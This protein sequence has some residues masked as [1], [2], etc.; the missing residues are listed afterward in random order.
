MCAAP[1]IEVDADR[2]RD[3][4]RP[5]DV[6]PLVEELDDIPLQ[7]SGGSATTLSV[8]LVESPEWACSSAWVPTF[9]PETLDLPLSMRAVA[10]DGSLDAVL[11]AVLSVDVATELSANEGTCGPTAAGAID[12]FEVIASDVVVPEGA[13][14]ADVAPAGE[15]VAVVSLRVFAGAE[16]ERAEAHVFS[17][18]PRDPGLGPPLDGTID[19]AR[20]SCVEVPTPGGLVDP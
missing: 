14:G 7:W 10:A 8:S 19:P 15:G 13:L 6:L 12:S 9:C 16:G 4:F 17:A 20:V 1:R 18:E 11:P 3:G 5:R 2:E